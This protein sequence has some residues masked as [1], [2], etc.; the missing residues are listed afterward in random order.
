MT[1]DTITLVIPGVDENSSASFTTPIMSAR[2]ILE[3]ARES[4]M[5][6]EVSGSIWMKWVSGAW[7]ETNRTDSGVTIKT[8]CSV[9][10]MLL[11]KELEGLQSYDRWD[12][13]YQID[14][15]LRSAMV[16]LHEAIKDL[17]PN[18]HRD[19]WQQMISATSA[20]GSSY[21]RRFF[22]VERFESAFPSGGYGWV[23]PQIISFNDSL[24]NNEHG[25]TAV[26]QVFEAAIKKAVEM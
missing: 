25:W 20:W 6:V 23:V 26:D 15:E 13:L 1:T 7:F 19:Y 3:Q 4:L 5:P 21:G 16:F 11:V 24:S 18:W 10:A 2:E 14:P 22:D 17:H 8:A 12:A 9:G